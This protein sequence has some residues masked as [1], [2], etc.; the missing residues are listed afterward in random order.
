MVSQIQDEE[1]SKENHKALK[2]SQKEIKQLQKNCK[3]FY[4]EEK[5]R[6][7][8]I[9]GIPC[10]QVKFIKTCLESTNEGGHNREIFITEVD[11]SCS[12]LRRDIWMMVTKLDTLKSDMVSEHNKLKSKYFQEKKKDAK[13]Q[14]KKDRA[15]TQKGAKGA[16][17]TAQPN[18]SQES[19]GSYDSF[20]EFEETEEI[21]EITSP[22]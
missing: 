12:N 8:V 19:W 7:T 16:V 6:R 3:K 10:Q 18:N 1:E 2:A 17:D 4:D 13:H 9:K 22:E 15:K 5:M 14:Q 11:E 20:I 21:P